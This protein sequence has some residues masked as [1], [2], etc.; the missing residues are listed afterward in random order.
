MLCRFSCVWLWSH[1][2]LPTSLLCSWDSP[3]KNT[4]VSCHALL[5]GIFLTQGSNLYVSGLLHLL[6]WQ[7]G[8]LPLSSGKPSEHLQEALQPGQ[9]IEPDSRRCPFFQMPCLYPNYYLDLYDN[10]VL[11]FMVL[12]SLY[13]C[14]I[15]QYGSIFPIF[16]FIHTQSYYHVLWCFA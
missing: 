16:I 10:L 5:K 3:D 6:H 8:F 2:L 13:I 9:E 7:T 15:E 12:P 14:T 1:G 4:G 11:F